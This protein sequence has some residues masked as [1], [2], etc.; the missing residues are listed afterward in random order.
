MD[1]RIIQKVY[2]MVMN[3]RNMRVDGVEWNDILVMTGNLSP[4]DKSALSK[5]LLDAGAKLH[6]RVWDF[7]DFR[8][9]SLPE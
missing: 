1:K 7:S 8:H 4:S 3:L 9:D 6:G 5:A 2:D